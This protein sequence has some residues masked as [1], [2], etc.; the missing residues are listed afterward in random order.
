MLNYW[1][2]IKANPPVPPAPAALPPSPPPV[3]P[4]PAAPPPSPPPATFTRQQKLSM[5]W[6]DFGCAGHG[7]GPW[8]GLGAVIKQTVRRAI[9][10]NKILTASVYITSPAEVAEHLHKHF[11]TAE[12]RETHVEKKVQEIIV[13]YSDA[14]DISERAG[15]ERSQYDPLTE[16]K[17]TFQY[18]MLDAGA[19]RRAPT[20]RAPTRPCSHALCSHAPCS[21]A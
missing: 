10:H 2:N 14:T 21:H 9:L 12:W 15:V 8:D 3:P 5:I 4:A 19:T 11:G 16:A 18:M 20:R 1:S 7:K 6:V 13:L 17:K